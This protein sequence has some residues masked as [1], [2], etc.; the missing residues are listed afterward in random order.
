[1]LNSSWYFCIEFMYITLTELLQA[2]DY[3]FSV[4]NVF[5][6]KRSSALG[7]YQNPMNKIVSWS[8][9]T[10][11]SWIFLRRYS[12]HARQYIEWVVGL[13]RFLQDHSRSSEDEF[14]KIRR[15]IPSGKNSKVAFSIM[16]PAFSS[17]S[18]FLRCLAVCIL[19][20][21]FVPV[22]FSGSGSGTPLDEYIAM[23]DNRCPN[24]KLSL[25]N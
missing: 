13:L 9:I 17:T 24:V 6:F 25:D 8:K 1:M 12:C 4:A 18:K 11:L 22:V 15:K 21:A 14:C 7:L 10:I 19:L 16:K 2:T 3:I 20:V 5:L 23:A